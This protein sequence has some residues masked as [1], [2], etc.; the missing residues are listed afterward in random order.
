MKRSI[1]IVIAILLL[2]TLSACGC[3]HEW[4]DATCTNAQSCILCEET[5]G[6]PLGHEWIDANCIEPQI[7][8]VC[9]ETQGEPLGHSPSDPEFKENNYVTATSVYVQKCTVCG[10][11]LDISEESIESLHNGT[12]FLISPNDFYKRLKNVYADIDADMDIR[13][14]TKGDQFFC[15]YLRNNKQIGFIQFSNE[16]GNITIEQKYD[17]CFN[18]MMGIISD[19]ISDVLTSIILT[20]DPTQTDTD[21]LAMSLSACATGEKK[22]ANGI[23]YQ[24]R[25][26]GNGGGIVWVDIK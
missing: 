14:G 13:S 4:A 26:D 12:L 3:K 17:S 16:S 11:D 19:D 25:V 10:E 15:G 7:C 6:T 1:V 24:C 23:I 2:V 9:H 18:G 20:C 5:Q 21:A 8:S 22:E